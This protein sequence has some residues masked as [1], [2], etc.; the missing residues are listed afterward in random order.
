MSDPDPRAPR[1]P[2]HRP[3]TGLAHFVSAFGWSMAGFR[4]ALGE[5]AFRQELALFVVLAPLAVW[6]GDSGVERALM[7]AALMLVLITELLN[8]AIEFTVDRIGSERHP[9][10]RSAKDLGSAAVFVAL[11]NV[12]VVWALVLLD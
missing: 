7:V 11:V 2:D 12:P 1:R 10:S 4:A 3:S 6:L 8:S 9:L 5:A